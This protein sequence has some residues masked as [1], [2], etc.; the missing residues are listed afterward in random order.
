MPKSKKYLFE[1][2]KERIIELY[3]S[4]ETLLDMEKVFNISR[5]TIRKYLERLGYKR[6]KEFVYKITNKKR[7]EAFLEKYGIE[8]PSQI[9]DPEMQARRI[10]GARERGKIAWSGK[11]NPNYKNK[12]GN[13]FGFKAGKRKDLGDMFFRSSWE[14]N[15]AR[16]LNHNNIDWEFEPKHFELENETTYT[17][18]FY[19]KETNEYIEVKGYWMEDAKE[20]YEMF[21]SQ[22]PEVK[23]R[24]VDEESYKQLIKENKS[25]IEFE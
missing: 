12:I 14:A 10:K 21:K 2:N 20:K 5:H 17:P 3:N 16:Y 1:Q 9:D 18:D 4:G 11:N 23:I 19:L 22:Y 24:L 15:Y 25:F 6:E 13:N 8:N 7:K